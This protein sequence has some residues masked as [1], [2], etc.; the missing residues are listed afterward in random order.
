MSSYWR[1]IAG[2]FAAI[3]VIGILLPS[4][5]Q[6]DREIVIDTYAATVFALLND[7]RQMNR[8]SG[9][10]G[11]DPN[12]R[13][14]ITGSPHGVGAGMSWEGRILGRGQQ[15]ITASE[16]FSSISSTLIL[17]SG[18]TAKVTYSLSEVAGKTQLNWTYERHFGFDLA[19]RLFAL[20]LDRIIGPETEKDLARL[21]EF[22]E[23]LP[24]A[25]FSELEV[26]Q[27]IVAANAIAYRKT[28][29]APD[30]GAISEAMGDAY[31]DILS[32]IDANDLEEAGAPLSITRTFS[33]SELVF[34]AAIPVRGIRDDTPRN[35]TIVKIG[36]TYAGPVIR[37]RHTGPYRTLGH[38]HQQIAAW[39]AA[40]GIK[41]NGDAWES[42][43][44]D[45]T[46]TVESELLT[47]VYYP[48]RY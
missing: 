46:R 2:F 20:M 13:I 9:I 11:D 10:R 5:V 12:A 30:A 40:L 19:G 4:R 29:S 37:V 48:V 39:L 27:L 43:I 25:D 6:V 17:D 18:K 42:Y 21:K 45:P 15:T 44:S 35:G 14:E 33:G 28:A 3:V 38:T 31:F 7:Y 23:Q 1:Y 16:P 24:K 41:R 22:A 34:D 8:W 26:E 36:E 32:F 47:Y